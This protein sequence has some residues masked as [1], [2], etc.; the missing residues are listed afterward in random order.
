M[1]TKVFSIDHA[2][3]KTMYCVFWKAGQYYDWVSDAWETPSAGSDA[4]AVRTLT[5]SELDGNAFSYYATAA[6]D[7]TK[8]NNTLAT[9]DVVVRYYEQAGGS[10]NI[11]SDAIIA[12]QPFS[13]VAGFYNPTIDI[14]WAPGHKKDESPKVASFFITV[15]ADGTPIDLSSLSGTAPGCTVTVFKEG[16]TT[17][18][19]TDSVTAPNSNGCFYVTRDTPGYVGDRTHRVNI[20]IDSGKIVRDRYFYGAA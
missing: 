2:S 5:E 17:A 15:T 18:E 16:N 12:A 9:T 19:F 4:N 11:T 13:V 6:Q 10:A 7:L 20:N 14:E 3:G 1:T 8:L